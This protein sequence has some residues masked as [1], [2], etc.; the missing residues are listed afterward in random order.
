MASSK[1]QN[2]GGCAQGPTFRQGAVMLRRSTAITLVLVA[3]NQLK[4]NFDNGE[5]YVPFHGTKIL[6]PER[7]TERHSSRG[8]SIARL[9]RRARIG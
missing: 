8:R 6:L 1:I 2:V 7:E 3:T 4:E 9:P 5:P